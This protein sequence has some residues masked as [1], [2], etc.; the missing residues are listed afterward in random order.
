MC[1]HKNISDAEHEAFLD[2]LYDEQEEYQERLFRNGSLRSVYD[3]AHEIALRKDII[4]QFEEGNV[5]LDENTLS[6]VLLTEDVIDKIVAAIYK[7]EDY[8]DNNEMICDIAEDAVDA[9]SKADYDNMLN[10]G[11]AQA[12]AGQGMNLDDAFKVINESI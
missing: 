10:T 3:S 4:F 11:L 8:S 7:H 5:E 1:N 9:M 2:K 12:K 6:R